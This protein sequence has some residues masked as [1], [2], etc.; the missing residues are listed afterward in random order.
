MIR[1]DRIEIAILELKPG[2]ILLVR[3]PPEW[4]DQMMDEASAQVKEAMRQTG[5]DVPALISNE[6]IEFKIVRKSAEDFAK[7]T[8]D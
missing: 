8:Q 3:V 5:V 1:Y 2:D 7:E 6:T 4:T